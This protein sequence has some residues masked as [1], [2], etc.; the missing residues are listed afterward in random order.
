[1]DFYYGIGLAGS[2]RPLPDIRPK[3]RQALSRRQSRFPAVLRCEFAGPHIIL[4]VFEENYRTGCAEDTSRDAVFFCYHLMRPGRYL[5][6]GTT[7]EGSSNLP[8]S[9]S[10]ALVENWRST[11]AGRAPSPEQ[12]GSHPRGSTGRR[13]WNHQFDFC[14]A[15][16]AMTAMQNN[17]PC[18]GNAVHDPRSHCD[19]W[20]KGLYR[21]FLICLQSV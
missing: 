9:G 10:P 2:R 21:L 13:R 1:V 15:T 8:R 11:T 20:R 17:A 12:F 4:H 18:N 19:L 14:D 7:W 5:I 6:R 16:N 3:I